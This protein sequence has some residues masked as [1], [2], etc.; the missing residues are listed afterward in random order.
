MISLTLSTKSDHSNIPVV[1]FYPEK[2]DQQV[3]QLATISNFKNKFGEVLF[4]SEDI[5][6]GVGDTELNSVNSRKL[7]GKLSRAVAHLQSLSLDLDLQY[8]QEFFRG[9]VTGR[10]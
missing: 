10:I 9:I 7:G 1:S 2:P 3:T 8:P 6:L 5:F 4:L